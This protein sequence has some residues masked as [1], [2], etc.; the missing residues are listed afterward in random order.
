MFRNRCWMAAAAIV[1]LLIAVRGVRLP[2]QQPAA[3]LPG[4][5]PAIDAAAYPT[6]QAAI[7]AL[8]PTGG[9]IRLPAGTFDI[10]EPLRITQEDV[11]LEGAGTATH[12]KNTNTAGQPAIVL[13]SSKIK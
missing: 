3:G 10:S 5:R 9:V 12:I 6:L 11:L 13:E 1:V 2:S 4:A 7:D 8:P